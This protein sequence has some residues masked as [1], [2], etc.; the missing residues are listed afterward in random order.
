MGSIHVNWC[1][2]VSMVMSRAMAHRF[3]LVVVDFPAAEAASRA[4]RSSRSFRL[5]AIS[6]KRGSKIYIPDMTP[7]NAATANPS[8]PP[9]RCRKYGLGRDG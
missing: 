5:T 1:I 3:S 6:L 4:S 2:K 9:D 8:V 7:T